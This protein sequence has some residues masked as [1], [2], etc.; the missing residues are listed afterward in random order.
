MTRGDYRRTREAEGGRVMSDRA[1][2]PQELK[3]AVE[4]HHKVMDEMAAA[5]RHVSAVIQKRKEEEQ[6][7]R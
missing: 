3:E 4:L 6:H 1:N 2:H 5:L 7:G